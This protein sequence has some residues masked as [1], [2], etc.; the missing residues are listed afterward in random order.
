MF[1]KALVLI[2]VVALG[3]AS[4]PMSAAAWTIPP[5]PTK[6][7]DA[8]STT[9]QGDVLA[10]AVP[11]NWQA[12]P[13]LVFVQGLHGSASSWWGPTSYSGD[14]DMYAYAYNNGYRSFFVQFRDADGNAGSMWLNGS[15]LRQQLEWITKYAGVSKVN[16]VAHSK[17]G[18]DSQ[19]AIVHYGAR[20]FVNRVLTLSSPHRG[21]EL[22]DLSYSWYAWWLGALMGQHD[23]GTYVMQTGYMDYFRSVTDGQPTDIAMNHYYTLGGGDWGPWFSAMWFG[24]SYLSAYGSND[25]V[26]RTYS[27]HALPGHSGDYT[28]GG[29]NH[30]NI[31]MGSRTF[32]W[33]NTYAGTTASLTTAS[34]FRIASLGGTQAAATTEPAQTTVNSGQ[35]FRG[36]QLT[37]G[38]ATESVPVESGATQA[39]FDV[40]ASAKGVDVTLVSPSGQR[41]AAT[42]RLAADEYFQGAE[43]IAL[44]VDKPEAGFWTIEINDP[45]GGDAGYLATATIDS[46]L[47]ASLA[48]TF[49]V[50]S[51]GAGMNLRLDLSGGQTAIASASAEGV[52]LRTA[53]GKTQSVKVTK[54]RLG[55]WMKGQGI[56]GSLHLPQQAG[57]YNLSLTVKGTLADGTPFERSVVTS[58]A[59]APAGQRDAAHLQNMG[60]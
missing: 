51:P 20:P 26:V 40:L 55:N 17:G 29:W 31:R 50:L 21:S 14:N 37:A 25:G 30:D 47:T 1:R 22:A 42:E 46:G 2:V 16:I 44:T 41:L 8:G 58:Y 59:V 24:G 35:V 3:L 60:K 54:Q 12:K 28:G 48:K 34:L 45:N 43:R 4:L 23:D 15:V 52:L 38:R 36:G 49:G 7:Y 53:S 56:Q 6:V 32:N 9:N 18:V 5:T 27:A 57:I 11:A 10:G 13:V 39:A 33:V 19:S